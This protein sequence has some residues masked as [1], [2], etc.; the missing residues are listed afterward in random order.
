MLTKVTAQY[1][2]FAGASFDHDYYTTRHMKITLDAVQGFGLVRLESEQVQ[3]PQG[4][5]DG[6]VVATTSVYFP[7]RASAWAALAAARDALKA[8]LVNYTNI[9]PE[10]RIAQVSSHQRATWQ[11][12][13][14]G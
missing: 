14:A 1:R 5:K 13:P 9:Q 11:F 12:A 3:W 6:Q 8:D 4:E 10:M 7:D 2:W